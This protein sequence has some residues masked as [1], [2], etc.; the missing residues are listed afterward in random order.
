MRCEVLEMGGFWL[1]RAASVL[2]CRQ[3][4]RHDVVKFCA[5]STTTPWKKQ[6]PPRGWSQIASVILTELGP[7]SPVGR[8]LPCTHRPCSL[9]CAEHAEARFQPNKITVSRL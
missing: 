9:S 8:S 4:Q 1:A 5:A 2:H 3:A 6:S 7:Q